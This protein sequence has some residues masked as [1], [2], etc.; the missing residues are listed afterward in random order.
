M[1]QEDAKQFMI[2]CLQAAGSEPGPAE[3][4]ADVMLEADRQGHFSH[5]MNR[6]GKTL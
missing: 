4:Q 3:E 6:L 1:K 5:G 2:N